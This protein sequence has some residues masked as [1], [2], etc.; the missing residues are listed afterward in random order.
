VLASAQIESNGS[1]TLEN[2][3][4]VEYEIGEDSKGPRPR[5]YVPSEPALI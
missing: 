2:R 4:H 5:R 1:R 3:Q